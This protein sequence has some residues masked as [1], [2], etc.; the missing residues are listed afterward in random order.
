MRM[1][2]TRVQNI[3]LL[4]VCF[5]VDPIR[6][7][8]LRLSASFFVSFPWPT[9]VLI[10]SAPLCSLLSSSSSCAPPAGAACAL[11]RSQA[12][13]RARRPAC[14]ARH[15]VYPHSH[16][17]LRRS[18]Q[19]P[20]PSP[21]AAGGPWLRAAA[22]AGNAGPRSRTRVA[23]AAQHHGVGLDGGRVAL[24]AHR[25]QLRGLH[26][27][28]S[29]LRAAAVC[30]P[31]GRPRLGARGSSLQRESCSGRAAGRRAQGGVSARG[32]PAMARR[33]PH[34]GP[35]R[36]MQAAERA[37][38]AVSIGA[39]KP[40]GPRYKRGATTK[41]PFAPA[42]DRCAGGRGG[43]V[44]GGRAGGRACRAWRRVWVARRA[45]AA[46]RGRPAASARCMDHTCRASEGADDNKEAR[47]SRRTGTRRWKENKLKQRMQKEE[48]TDSWLC[49][50]A[51]LAPP[52]TRRGAR[53][54]HRPWLTRSGTAMA[55]S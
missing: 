48:L 26:G 31:L 46:A 54:L 47:T 21:Q 17:A 44:A 29:W 40:G 8:T 38:P 6:S 23:V 20:R 35:R 7:R 32:G 53:T 22:A 45:R 33:G 12:R 49:S 55:A 11:R 42:A 15:T 13:M 4:A 24:V 37:G 36:R 2:T 27:A 34:R 9:F 3:T 16:P 39:K 10:S 51:G 19:H 43:A 14:A 41:R 1:K 28:H 5:S 25:A 52:T 30:A 18:S 50:R